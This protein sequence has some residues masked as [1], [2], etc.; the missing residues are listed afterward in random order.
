M[1]MKTG[2]IDL[3]APELYVNRELSQLEFN[4]R[5]LEQAKD[6]RVPLLER[7]SYLCIS[8]RIMDEFFEVRVAGLKERLAHGFVQPG[9]DGLAP[10][11]ALDAISRIAHELVGEQYR[12]LNRV[13]IPELES[14]NIRLL[15]RDAWDARLATWV[16]RFF[17]SQ[18]LPVLS[19]MG[20]DPAHP[21]PKVLNKS[22]NFIV[23]L[24][25]RDAFGR[26]RGLAV[27]QAP[28]SLPRV[29]HVPEQYTRGPHDFVFLS[30]VIHA[31]VGDL[32]P[33]MRVEGC[34][35][36]RATRNSELFVEDE[37]VDDLLRAVEGE[38]PGRRFGS[39]VRLE[40]A[41]NCPGHLSQFLLH[42][43]QL[44]ERD[45][46]AVNGPVNLGRLQAIHDLV[47]RPE[48]KFP[49]FTPRVSPVIARA[50]DIFE[51]VRRRDLL[52]HH[53]FDAFTPLIELL[54]R[55]AVDPDV[56]AIKQT[57]YRTGPDSPVV[58]ALVEAA[59]GGKEVT[60]II[61]LRARFDEEANVRLATRLQEAGAHV[62]YGVVGYKTHAKMLLIV[63]RERGRLRRYAHLG[64]GNYHDRTAR[65]YTDMGLVTT[66]L[67]I[68]GDVQK[69]F[70]ML[71]GFGKAIK[72]KRCLHSPF[73]LHKA[74]LD[75]IAAEAASAAAGRPARIIAKLNGLTE[76][77]LIRALYKASQAG[78][79][80]DL[81]VR[82]VCCLRPGVPGASE[83]IRVRSIVGRFLEHTRIYCFHGDGER[84]V[85]LS[86]AD[87][88]DRNFFLRVE[89]A[90]P[91]LD[92][93][94]AER[95]VAEG[96]TSYL[97]DNTE[98]W[99]MRS[100]GRYERARAGNARRRAAQ[101][102]LV[103]GLL[104]RPMAAG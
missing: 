51:V 97:D 26:Q 43:F 98:A 96:L 44:D 35:Q 19:P 76:P 11:A 90:F 42:E 45:L 46:F 49:S 12:V 93:E 65:S 22:L 37:E 68:T 83:N 39:A 36:F 92:R 31:H 66:D 69:L 84:R 61:E 88:M 86:S 64:T 78:V 23:S 25:G 79:D 9:P 6:A 41:E 32:F 74:V 7:L 14:E 87:W 104:A 72:L 4:R 38:L 55:A 80:I 62:A 1:D 56:L 5:V 18:V 15:A 20:L 16:R 70:Q 8:S 95:A 91:L 102:T 77:E 50:S 47:D 33:G 29:I 75:L 53:P 58:D 82:G 103:E 89:C 27:V 2:G 94:V 28:R 57:L 30:S 54:R 40:V 17:N 85:L 52:L 13:L 34:Y 99:L 67:G 60:V 3:A 100:D 71:T 21:F 101:L 63:R 73:T 24:S 10:A 59:R 81:I 48:L